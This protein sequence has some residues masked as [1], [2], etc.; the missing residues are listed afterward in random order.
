ME[1]NYV[2]FLVIM[3]E[4]RFNYFIFVDLA[5]NKNIFIM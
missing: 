1:N 3:K 4:M 2:L 5:Y